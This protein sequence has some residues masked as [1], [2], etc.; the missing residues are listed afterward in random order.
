VKDA[1]KTEEEPTQELAAL[2]LNNTTDCN[3]VLDVVGDGRFKVVDLNPSG[4][5]LAGLSAVDIVG[6]YTE[7]FLSPGLADAM[8]ANCRRCVEAGVPIHYRETLQLPAGEASFSTTLVPVKDAAGRICR[9]VGIARDISELKR[10]EAALLD[11]ER[12]FRTIYDS[13]EEAIFVHDLDTGAILDA[14][15]KASEMFGYVREDLRRLTIEDLSSGE[16][17][18]T[19]ADAL[20]WL[21]K[22][23]GG[24]VQIFEWRAKDR[25]GRL[26]WIE[27][28]IKRTAIGDQ[29]LLLATGHDI[30]ARKRAEEAAKRHVKLLAAL[31]KGAQAIASSLDL[32]TV[33][34]QLIAEMPILFEAEAASVLLCDSARGELVFA[35]ADSPSREKLTGTRMPLNSGIAG[36]VAREKQA[37]L[38][39]DAQSDPRFYKHVDASTRMTTRSLLAVPLM[40]ETR[41][42]GVIE[43]LNKAGPGFDAS[44]LDLMKALAGPA[45]VA[46]ENARL[47]ASQ[48][49]A[50]RQEQAMRAQ[51]VQAGKLSA[52]GR[53]VASVAHELN[54]PLQTIRNCLF[55]VQQETE[56]EKESR[57]YLATATSEIRRLANLVAQ[58]RAVYR[59]VPAEEMQL[60]NLRDIV[61]EVRLLTAPHLAENRSRWECTPPPATFIVNGL[62]DQLK[63]VFLNISLNAIDAMRPAGGTLTISW[64]P[65]ADGRQVGVAFKDTGHGVEADEL[66]NLFEPFFTTKETGM[67]LGLAICYDIVRRHG[68][69]IEVDSQPGQG[70]TFTVWLP[71]ARQT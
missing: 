66:P 70:A 60:I 40:Y 2:M 68:G 32:D 61:E 65:A 58:L 30:T 25:T 26:F 23:A 3:L 47:Y 45:A 37:A 12:R 35:A 13:V 18:Y 57:K 39:N 9:I 31:N 51:L 10:A 56:P 20:V 50:L 17:P 4:E 38:V 46:I 5:R 49:E 55:L 42:I 48:A 1:G 19:Q 63:Q 6:K 62:P 64:S 52:M 59:P 67:G 11:S 16:P 29:I 34:K 53:M 43:A 8:N 27:I 22:A 15:R 21:K 54:N 71:L 44:D 24:E 7:E 33:L 28:N 14:N 41:V 69:R 36:W